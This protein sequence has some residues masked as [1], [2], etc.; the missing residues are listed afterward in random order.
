[1]CAVP[2]TPSNCLLTLILLLTS[3]ISR[4]KNLSVLIPRT[5]FDTT[6]S[7]DKSQATDILVIIPVA[8]VVPIP[9]PSFKNEVLNPI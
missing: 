5:S 9:V 1:M 7:G 8:P 2:K 4:T 3:S 6:E